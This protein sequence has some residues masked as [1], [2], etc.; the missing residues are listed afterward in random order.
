[1]ALSRPKSGFES[2]YRYQIFRKPIEQGLSRNCLL[3]G[4]GLHFPPE[5][6]V[7]RKRRKP[8]DRRAHPKGRPET[9]CL[10]AQVARAGCRTSPFEV[11]GEEIQPRCVGYG[12]RLR[13]RHELH[14]RISSGVVGGPAGHVGAVGI[15]GFGE[16]RPIRRHFLGQLVIERYPRAALYT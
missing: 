13:V 14:G 2:R 8:T 3:L 11:S 7:R 12:N 10:A 4:D 16:V 1:M 9:P 15:S 6:Q 5:F